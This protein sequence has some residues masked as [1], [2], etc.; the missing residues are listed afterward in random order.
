[1]GVRVHWGEMERDE[2]RGK[3]GFR[4]PGGRVERH[5][6][7]RSLL[8]R[9]KNLFIGSRDMEELFREERDDRDDREGRCDDKGGRYDDYYNG[10]DE[11]SRSASLTTAST[12]QRSVAT[13]AE[14]GLSRGGP[15]VSP[16]TASRQ[17]SRRPLTAASSHASATTESR[18]STAHF[19][20]PSNARS[21]H[22]TTRSRASSQTTIRAKPTKSVP[23]D[24]LNDDSISPLMGEISDD[25][26]FDEEYA[27]ISQGR[28]KKNTRWSPRDS[29]TGSEQY[30]ALPSLVTNTGNG[31]TLTGERNRHTGDY[32][33]DEEE[34]RSSG[35]DYVLR[36]P[37]GRALHK[38]R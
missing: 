31:R 21:R 4:V 24:P 9:I 30:V 19:S 37:R 1:M 17:P 2:F 16:W 8:S 28:A 11:V 13:S 25:D 27:V 33:S 18:R 23:Q 35:P 7:T 5:P 14:S 36:A 3:R 6:K 20:A 10:E 12:R 38:E 22:S 26:L 15:S 34:R 32:H 29:Q